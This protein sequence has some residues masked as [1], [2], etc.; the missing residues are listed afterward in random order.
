MSRVVLV[1]ALGLLVTAPV[2]HAAPPWSVPESVSLPALTIDSPH[3]AFDG[4]GRAFATWRPSAGD[5]MAVRDARAAKFL[6]ERSSPSFVT[7]LLPYASSRVIGL[8]QRPAGGRDVVSLRARVTRPDTS[9]GR[10]DTIATF[11]LGSGF[12]SLAVHDVALAAW[13]QS[14]RRGRAIVRAAIRRRGQRFGRPVTLRARGRARNL[15][16]AAGAGAMFV[17]WERAGVVEARVRLAGRG[18]GP[19]RRIASTT[20]GGNTFRAAFSGSRGYLAWLSEGLESSVLRVAV[21]PATGTR[22]R[23]AQTLDTYDRN[24]PVEPHGPALVPLPARQAML[25]WNDW[26]GTAWRVLVA[27]SGSGARFG[28]PV[29][30]SPAGEQAVL[31]AAAVVP[32]SAPVPTGTA[33]V[34]WSRLDAVGEVGDHV[35]AALRPPGGTF[36]AP[37][38]V[39]DLDRARVPDVAFDPVSGR[40]TVVFSQRIGPD[41]GVPLNQITTFLRTATRPG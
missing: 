16:A 35:R 28:A 23:P 2:A 6:R 12:P 38:N 32:Q 36:G 11:R 25:A 10:V 30:I 9:F 34:V 17:A 27:D 20:R 13:I 15:V 14:G 22:F 39:S 41:Q 18:W 24:P 5:A 7:P 4:R 19:V 40:W 31:G 1:A 3:I 33:L 26:D 37:E 21:L 29:V 8:D